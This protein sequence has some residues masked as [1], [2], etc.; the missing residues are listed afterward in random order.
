MTG[1]FAG[2]SIETMQNRAMNRFDKDGSGDISIAEA[3][4]RG[5]LARNFTLIDAN[6]D[7]LLTRD[8]LGNAM[9]ARAEGT[10][11]RMGP[12]RMNAMAAWMQMQN[13]QSQQVAEFDRI[14]SDG[15]G[16]LSDGELAA[17][18]AAIEAAEEAARLRET[19][20]AEMARLDSD[21]DGRLSISELQAELDM[22]AETRAVAEFDRLDSDGN[23]SLSDGELAAE[24]SAQQ[25]AAEQQAQAEADAAAIAESVTEE[26][27]ETAAPVEVAQEATDTVEVAPITP[28]EAIPESA[29]TDEPEVISLIENVFEELLEDR[30]LEVSI[31]KLMSMS[32]SLYQDAQEILM[33]Q[34]ESG[35]EAEEVAA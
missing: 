11:A 13:A 33:T 6:D 7:G 26:I 14:D 3:G 12:A 24:V 15:D 10:Y 20:I 31:D 18:M 4:D 8:E 5:R 22:R 16:M 25:A 9:A 17:E 27:A 23:G 29:E 34:L 30:G 35:D 19:K 28:A 21:G 1:Q 2:R 32:Q